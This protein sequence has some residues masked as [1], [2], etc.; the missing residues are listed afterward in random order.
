[1]SY[2]S[3]QVRRI[4]ID[5]MKNV[6]PIYNIKVSVNSL[7]KIP[8]AKS[9]Y[10]QI[11][12]CHNYTCK[13]WSVFFFPKKLIKCSKMCWED[14]E[15][16]GKE[17]SELKGNNWFWFWCNLMKEFVWHKYFINYSIWP[18]IYFRLNEVTFE[19]VPGNN[20]YWAMG[21][22]CLA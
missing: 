22:K 5:T 6:H 3:F 15:L 20:Q 2:F 8:K 13:I 7:S 10:V 14:S 9:V 4:V 17:D 19:V 18:S 21:V 16:K 12:Y 11:P 1:M